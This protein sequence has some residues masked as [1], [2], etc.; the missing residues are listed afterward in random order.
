MMTPLPRHKS[1]YRLLIHAVN[2]RY[3]AFSTT[4]TPRRRRSPK[5]PY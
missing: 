5:S 1:L 4:P 2:N 3:I